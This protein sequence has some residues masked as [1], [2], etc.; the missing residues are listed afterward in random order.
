MPN[1]PHACTTVAGCTAA[2]H[3]QVTAGDGVDGT[4]GRV[5][6][7]ACEPH[8]PVAQRRASTKEHRQTIRIAN[9]E[10]V[11]PDERNHP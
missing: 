2:A 4:R 5:Y 6:L 7:R 10:P 11:L 1:D 9:K 3:Y 8:L